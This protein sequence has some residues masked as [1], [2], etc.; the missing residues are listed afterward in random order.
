MKKICL[1]GGTGILGKY[2]SSQLSRHNELHIADISL[3][4]LK[5]SKK[6]FTYYLDLDNENSVEEFFFKTKKKTV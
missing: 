2:F 5:K 4:N 3:T 6:E 1:I